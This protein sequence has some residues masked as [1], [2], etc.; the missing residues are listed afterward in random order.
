[1]STDGEVMAVY[2]TPLSETKDKECWKTGSNRIPLF[3]GSADVGLHES[4]HSSG[5]LRVR[6]QINAKK[7]RLTSREEFNQSGAPDN[8]LLV[9]FDSVGRVLPFLAKF[10][11]PG[12]SKCICCKIQSPVESQ[13][14]LDHLPKWRKQKVTRLKKVPKGGRPV[15]ADSNDSISA[16]TSF[17]L[18]VLF[19]HSYQPLNASR[20]TLLSPQMNGMEQSLALKV[21][22]SIEAAGAVSLVENKQYRG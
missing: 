2:E 5:Q 14:L 22:S 3:D 6:V 9:G 18:S 15:A 10:L 4:D 11:K 12:K 19:L 20:S 13:S 17:R 16:K 1:M 8:S 7:R 21:D